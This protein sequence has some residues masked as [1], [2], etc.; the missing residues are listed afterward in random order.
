MRM[1]LFS[2]LQLDPRSRIPLHRQLYA[3]LRTA[4]LTG[5]L[6]GGTRLTPTRALANDLG[7]SRNTVID[8]YEQ[9][10][11]EGYFETISGVG[12]FVSPNLAQTSPT[13]RTREARA[14]PRSAMRKHLAGLPSPAADT[15]LPL[16]PGIPAVEQFPVSV[17]AHLSSKWAAKA[18][19]TLLNYGDPLGY[20]PLREAIADYLGAA[21]GVRCEAEQVVIVGGAQQGID[22]A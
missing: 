16:C 17:W 13:V 18:S 21:R 11:V 2:A 7:V 19:R 12:T 9:L 15:R 10:I 20:R 22:L 6:K 5:R 14:P 4:V 3:E 1:N 8:A